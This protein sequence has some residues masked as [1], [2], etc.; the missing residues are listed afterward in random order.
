M[1]TGA[2]LLG[3]LSDPQGL[4]VYFWDTISDP[5]VFLLALIV[6]LI[7][8]IGNVLLTSGQI[9]SLV[10]NMRI[11]KKKFLLFFPALVGMLP[12]PGGALLS[13]PFVE[14]GGKDIDNSAK[15]GINVWFRHTLYLVYPLSPGLIVSA[16]ILSK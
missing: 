16:Q 2:A 4:T 13:A 1:V 3:V 8:I 14:K 9:D 6:G 12:M 15:A 5:T 10:S 7:P 11:G